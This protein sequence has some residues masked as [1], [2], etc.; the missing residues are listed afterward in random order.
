MRIVRTREVVKR[1]T[2]VERE[3]MATWSTS[4]SIRVSALASP[5]LLFVKVRAIR[6]IRGT[7]SYSDHIEKFG[8]ADRARVSFA[9]CQSVEM[10]SAVDGFLHCYAFPPSWTLNT[11]LQKKWKADVEKIRFWII[12]VNSFAGIVVSKVLRYSLSINDNN[13]I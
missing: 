11:F 3:T 10:S 5:R 7:R 9:N 6:I 2:D 8:G 1:K 12:M 4:T 13:I